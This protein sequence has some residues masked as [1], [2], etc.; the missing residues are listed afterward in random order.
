MATHDP[1]PINRLRRIDMI[2]FSL[3]IR[4]GMKLRVCLI[5]AALV[6]SVFIFSTI[7]LAED[8]NQRVFTS[9][10]DA[11]RALVEAAKAHNPREMVAILGPGSKNII[12]SGDRVA[13]REMRDQFV[14]HY[15]E[16]NRIDTSDEKKAVLY[17]GTADWPF[18]VPLVGTGG[19]WKFD[20]AE[21]AREV[22]NRRVGKNEL[23][24]I[25]ACLAYVDAQREYAAKRREE[26][27]SSEYAQKFL[28]EPGKKNGLFWETAEG[29]QPSPMG[30]LVASATEEGYRF[31]ATGGRPVPYHGYFY[32][33]LKAQGKNAP[34]GAYS[35]IAKDKMIGGFA[36]VAYPAKYGNSGVMTFMVNQDGLVFQ[37]DLGKNTVRTAKKMTAFDPDGGWKKVE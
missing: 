19:S 34:G 4:T 3:K 10:D 24:A 20:G 37:K 29:E 23:S 8:V 5:V 2:D 26:G 35:Y 27:V 9:A 13:D 30:P 28:S 1:L 15:E 17:V 11:A 33:I 31:K 16:K 18:P 25:Q 21:G 7:S 36:L 12:S 22:L 14:K 32:K 6:A